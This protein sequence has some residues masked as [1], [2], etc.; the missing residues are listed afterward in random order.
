MIFETSDHPDHEFRMVAGDEEFQRR[1]RAELQ[2]LFE[3]IHAQASAQAG[4]EMATFYSSMMN[5]YLK[6]IASNRKTNISQISIPIFLDSFFGQQPGLDPSLRNIKWPFGG[7]HHPSDA[8]SHEL[9]HR[10]SHPLRGQ[11]HV[12][13]SANSRSEQYVKPRNGWTLRVFCWKLG[14]CLE[15]QRFFVG[16]LECASPLQ[17]YKY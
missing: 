9:R 16:S 10:E 2:K 12:Q 3:A 5:T 8:Q 4:F 11:S 7:R 13:I 15:T 14:V 6:K 1:F 17:Y